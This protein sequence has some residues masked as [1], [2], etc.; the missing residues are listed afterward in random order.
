MGQPVF[1]QGQCRGDCSR[2]L[3]QRLVETGLSSGEASH[4]P[5]VLQDSIMV[6]DQA[7]FLKSRH[8]SSYQAVRDMMPDC[9]YCMSLGPLR[10]AP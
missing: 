8:S 2:S 6:A 10:A 4:G 7:I 5:A 1:L 9:Q 3:R